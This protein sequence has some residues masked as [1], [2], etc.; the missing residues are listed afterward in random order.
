MGPVDLRGSKRVEGSETRVSLCHELSTLY[1]APRK[2]FCESVS[3][4]VKRSW[5]WFHV[6]WH[7]S[8][9]S[10]SLAHP[11]STSPLFISLPLSLFLSLY[12]S[13]SRSPF[14]A[15]SPPPGVLHLPLPSSTLPFPTSA[16]T[17]ALQIALLP[18]S[19]W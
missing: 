16:L 6:E 9:V 10:L 2:R 5:Y 18:R 13:I 19:Y 11:C 17:I 4:F 12:V 7:L 14:L 3:L 1:S 8:S 15:L